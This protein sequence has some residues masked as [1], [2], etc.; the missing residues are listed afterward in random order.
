MFVKS[1]EK[2]TLAENFQEAI[3]VEKNLVAISSHSGNKESKSSTSKQN[4]KKSKWI[5]KS[6]SKDH[7]DMDNMHRMIKQLKSEVINLK[8]INGKGKKLSKPF[9]KNKTN[10]NTS[11]QIPSTSGINLEDYFLDNFCHTHHTNHSDKT[12]P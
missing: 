4:G 6:K 10:T 7:T 9:L 2:W 1:K 3:K 8:K 5:Y 11:P 12:C